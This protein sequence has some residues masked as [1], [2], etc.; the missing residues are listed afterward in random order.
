MIFHLKNNPKILSSFRTS[1][2]ISQYKK[3]RKIYLLAHGWKIE[4]V[5]REIKPHILE[6]RQQ[7]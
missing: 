6:T 7:T 3:A 1:I 2:F 5:E 4:F